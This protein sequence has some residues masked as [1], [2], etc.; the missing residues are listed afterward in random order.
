MSKRAYTAPPDHL[1]CSAPRKPLADGSGARCM[2]RATRGPLCAQHHKKKQQDQ[3]RADK[4]T[5]WFD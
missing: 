1:R 2:K 5:F 4:E 3:R